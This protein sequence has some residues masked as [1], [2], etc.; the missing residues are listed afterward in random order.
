[1]PQ[2]RRSLGPT[3]ALLLLT[4]LA[5]GCSGSDDADQPAAA[6]LAASDFQVSSSKF[7]EIRPKVRIPDEHT[8]YGDNLSPPLNWS[9]APDG[10]RSLALIADDVDHRAGNWV[11]WILYNIPA[12]VTELTTGIATTT[13]VLPDGMT[14]GTNDERLPGYAGPCPPP[15]FIRWDPG[16]GGA[17][18]EPAHKYV[19]T[20]YALDTELDLAAGAT[21]SK[22]LDAMDGHILAQAEI[23]GKYQTKPTT[24]HK[25]DLTPTATAP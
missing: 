8:C 1:M 14:Q 15:V 20:L 18:P 16:E 7:T 12:D 21:K 10:T 11:H 22:L 9:G 2:T 3:L 5:L 17:T 19:F 23:V 6:Q 24:I 4:L 25:G 13:D